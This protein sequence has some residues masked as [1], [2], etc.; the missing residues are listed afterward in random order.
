[1]IRRVGQGYADGLIGCTRVAVGAVPEST[2]QAVSTG[3]KSFSTRGGVLARKRRG[4]RVG[5]PVRGH[6]AG[7]AGNDLLYG[8][9][10]YD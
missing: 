7:R 3:R 5:A 2:S 4:R 6:P 1:M 9:A 10:G 8:Q